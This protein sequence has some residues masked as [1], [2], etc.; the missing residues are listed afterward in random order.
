[1]KCTLSALSRQLLIV[2]GIVVLVACSSTKPSAPTAAQVLT[3][4][5]QDASRIEDNVN[6]VV[7]AAVGQIRYSGR[8]DSDERNQAALNA[9]VGL[10]RKFI[11]RSLPNFTN[12]FIE[13][14]AELAERVD[15]FLITKNII[16]ERID[17][18]NKTYTI[19]IR[20]TI[21]EPRLISFLT[22]PSDKMQASVLTF[23][24]V[25]RE[26]PDHGL[27]RQERGKKTRVQW[28]MEPTTA[29]E[30][31]VN[32]VFVNNKFSV[33][34]AAF[35]EKDTHYQFEVARFIA[36]YAVGDDISQNVLSDALRGLN[37]LEP[38]VDYLALGTLDVD[39]SF[40][41]PVTGNMKVAVAA[42]GQILKVNSRGMQVAS[43]GPV[44]YFGEGATYQ[45]AKNNA[46]RSAAQSVA[47]TLA[48]QLRARN[49]R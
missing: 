42:T 30:A 33:E 6:T 12:N 22:G 26:N 47:K 17:S 16:D 27:E 5:E 13:K 24:F 49:I 19:T 20:S 28:N 37:T 3:V 11:N 23:V 2:M 45:I 31:A 35:L 48:A 15:E 29:F 21:D 41:D 34:R 8:L 10:I 40:I 39:L 25:A 43:V 44:Q 1:M 4:G 32:Q 9:K 36:D 7:A 18:D 14:E 38:P 46:L